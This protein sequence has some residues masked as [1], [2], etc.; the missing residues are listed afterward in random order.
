MKMFCAEIVLH[1]PQ[2]F[3]TCPLLYFFGLLKAF[4]QNKSVFQK[5]TIYRVV[6]QQQQT[7]VRLPYM[8]HIF[9]LLQEK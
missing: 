8:E 9:L 7:S 6:L 1:Q 5:T 4:L 2:V 3:V